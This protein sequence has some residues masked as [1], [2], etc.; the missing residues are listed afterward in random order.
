MKRQK[1]A[2]LALAATAVMAGANAGATDLT[3]TTAFSNIGITVVDLTP[4]DGVAGGISITQTFSSV[5]ANAYDGVS[6][7]SDFHSLHFSNM[8]P[9]NVSASQGGAHGE[10]HG[11][12][13]L[14]SQSSSAAVSA[15]NQ[16]A[17]AFV[18]ADNRYDVAVLPN[19]A[20]TISG[21]LAMSV[22]ATGNLDFAYTNGSG[23][24]GLNDLSIGANHGSG[25]FS[26]GAGFGPVSHDFSYTYTNNTAQTLYAEI[27]IGTS[28]SAY[29]WNPDNIPAVPE[30]ETYLMLGAGLALLGT[31]ARRRRS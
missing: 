31:V 21:H 5:Q 29:I 11:S 28:S 7:A 15:D 16:N 8:D 25:G 24:F 18:S 17:A 1:I 12:G 6:P 19:T 30:P 14:S 2:L 3:S 26:Y 20:F 22:G 23:I 13:T 10:I 27:Q 4:S 9:I